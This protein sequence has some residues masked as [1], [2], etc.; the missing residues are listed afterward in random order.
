MDK[1]KLNKLYE[2]I[3]DQYGE[4]GENVLQDMIDEGL[5][6]LIYSDD[7]YFVDILQAYNVMSEIDGE[8]GENFLQE[9]LSPAP[10]IYKDLNI[11]ISLEEETETILISHT[12]SS[13]VEYDMN[14][15]TIGE[16]MADY[17]ENFLSERRFLADE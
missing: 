6:S 12:G 15:Y 13:G 7:A 17:E 3:N 8:D 11:E 4:D 16:A 10:F 14:V 1:I 2:L 9:Y 5:I